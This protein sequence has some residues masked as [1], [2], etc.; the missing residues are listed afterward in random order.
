MRINKLLM[1]EY[2]GKPYCCLFFCDKDVDDIKRVLRRSTHVF[3]TELYDL[4]AHIYRD[5]D[6]RR[7][8]AIG[9]SLNLDVVPSL[10]NDTAGW[11]EAKAQHWEHWLV[12]CLFSSIF[13][14]DCGC[15]YGRVSNIN[16]ALLGAADIPAFENFRAQ[17]QN[18]SGM[19]KAEFKRRFR[20]VQ[21]MIQRL[22]SKGMLSLVF[23]GKW[24]ETIIVAELRSA[25]GGRGRATISGPSISSAAMALFD[26]KSG[27]AGQHIQRIRDLMAQVL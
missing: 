2:K 22:R 14:V 8:I 6:L 16:P 11:I 7:A 25:L 5:C 27:W 15:S 21:R 10:Y 17:L 24:L 23:R 13:N 3:Y 4:E 12:L 20:S 18:N 19:G 1:T 26:F 9:L